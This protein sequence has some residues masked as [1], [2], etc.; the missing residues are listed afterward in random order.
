MIDNAKDKKMSVLTTGQPDLSWAV[1]GWFE[2]I[3]FFHMQT[4]LIDGFAR[5]IPVPIRTQGTIQ[6]MSQTL[7][8]AKP[9]G[10]RSWRWLT[11]HCMPDVILKPNDKI[12]VD[13]VGYRVK[14]IWDYRRNGFFIYD[15]GEDFQS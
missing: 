11:I 4:Q 10:M 7:V 13:G 6:P 8:N 3:V 1:D 12:S 15:C 5:E 2:P 14:G 9:E